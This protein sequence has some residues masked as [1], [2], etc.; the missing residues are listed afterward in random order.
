MRGS[1]EVLVAARLNLPR[2][3]GQFPRQSGFRLGVHFQRGMEIRN[4]P[5]VSKCNTFPGHLDYMGSN[6]VS[7][8]KFWFE[9]DN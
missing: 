9:N 1:G 2:R 3:Q 5:I 4:D 6:R 7:N 8:V